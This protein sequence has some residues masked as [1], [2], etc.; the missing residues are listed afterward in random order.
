MTRRLAPAVLA[1]LI[2]AALLAACASTPPAP[3]PATPSASPAAPGQT[4]ASRNVPSAATV[5]T[6]ATRVA[7]ATPLSDQTLAVVE[8]FFT[9]YRASQQR[10]TLAA[11]TPRY[12][13]TLRTLSEVRQVVGVAPADI[14]SVQLQ[15]AVSPISSALFVDVTLA[16]TEGERILRVELRPVESGWRINKIETVG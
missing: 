5:S 4:P 7:V 11:L 15:P 8:W 9:A 13:A 16:T 2:I 10:E 3:A 12:A 14:Q 6:A 1:L